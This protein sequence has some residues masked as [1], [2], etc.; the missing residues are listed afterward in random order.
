VRVVRPLATLG[1]AIARSALA[2]PLLLLLLPLL[3]ALRRVVLPA[4]PDPDLKLDPLVAH[5]EPS[6]AQRVLEFHHPREVVRNAAAAFGAAVRR[7]VTVVLDLA[8]EL[9]HHLAIPDFFHDDARRGG[10]A[11][12]AVGVAVREARLLQDGFERAAQEL[13]AVQR[14]RAVL[15]V[16]VG[17]GGLWRR[18]VVVVVTAVGCGCL[19]GGTCYTEF[20][21]RLG[22]GRSRWE[23]AAGGR[24][25]RILGGNCLRWRA[26]QRL[27]SGGSGSGP[28]RAGRCAI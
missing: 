3:V 19:R 4:A 18:W 8:D 20:L 10:G 16:G 1:G 2:L 13:V 15:R 11:S 23:G 6:R 12:R 5:V 9:D 14:A 7:G 17:V 22:E 25:D 24:G 21:L 28:H 27:R 26:W